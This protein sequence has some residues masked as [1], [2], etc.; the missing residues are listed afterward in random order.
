MKKNERL[1]IVKAFSKKY[2]GASKKIKGQVLKEVAEATLYSR[3]HLMEILTHPVRIKKIFRP[4]IS[5]YQ[6]VFKSLKKLWGISNFACGKRLVPLIKTYLF[7]LKRHEG[8]A[9]SSEDKKKLLSI[10]PAT[11]DRL[12]KHERKRITLKGRCRTK[13]GTL[14]KNQIPVRTFSDWDEKEPGYGEID[15]VHHCGGNPAGDYLY[16]LDLTD[17]ATGWNECRAH[18][19]KSETRTVEALDKIRKR[20]P[21]PLKGVD[22][23]TGGEFVNWH[24][25]RYCGKNKINYTRA[26]EGKKNDQCFV[27]Q[28]NF[29]V[30]RRF[31]GYVRLDTLQQLKNLNRLYD[32]LSD[33]QNFFQTVGRV[34]EKVRN[35]TRLTRRYDPPQTPYQRVSIHPKIDVEIKKKLRRR[36]LKLNPRKLI[37]EIN[38]LGRKLSK[39]G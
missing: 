32:L 18:L 22:F 30:V 23:D 36:F 8:W 14:L 20:L 7:S 9:V 17:V 21:F 10:S 11:V 5:P 2:R 33:Y 38:R 3:K 24:L 15:S 19:G 27:E 1:T 35:G 25:I 26:R 39:I 16:S 13:P 28:Q 34:R 31:V 4:R 29:S 37:L 12:L 6:S